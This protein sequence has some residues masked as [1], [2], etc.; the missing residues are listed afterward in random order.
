LTGKYRPDRRPAGASR[1]GEDPGRGVEAYD[2]RNTSRTWDI[3]TALA[4]VAERHD[5]PMGQI[6]LAWLLSRPGVASILLGARTTTQLAEN[7][8]ALE[9]RLSPTEIER[10][11]AVSAPGL[12]PYPY[13]M[14]EDFCHV[15]VWHQLG[16]SRA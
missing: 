8:D 11:T 5:R 16:T 6:A 2:R 9:V 4:E 15:D 13:R 12:P 10:L 1:L 14:I 7:L 3:I